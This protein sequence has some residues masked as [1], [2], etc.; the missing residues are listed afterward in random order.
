MQKSLS[1]NIIVIC[2]FMEMKEVRMQYALVKGTG[3]SLSIANAKRGLK[4]NCYCDDCKGDIIAAKGDIYQ[5]YFRHA[6]DSTNCKGG[7]E[8]VLHQ[9]A[10][11][12]LVKSSNL[13]SSKHGE[14]NYTKAEPEKVLISIRPDVTAEHN[15]EKILF[16]IAVTHPIEKGKRAHLQEHKMRCIEID[17][18]EWI[19]TEPDEEELEYAV[20]RNPNN[21]VDLFWNEVV[22]EIPAPPKPKFWKSL[23]PYVIAG[24]GLLGLWIYRSRKT[25]KSPSRNQQ[26]LNNKNW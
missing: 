26:R 18:S 2:N 13:S 19:K 22:T 5:P 17:L 24:F 8:T 7:R 15:G 16:E 14:I 10:K 6:A 1:G 11:E 23:I 4:C 3:A 9:R 20:L 12:L 21:R 25:K